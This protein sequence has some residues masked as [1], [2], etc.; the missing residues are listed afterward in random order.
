MALVL[1][2]DMTLS[3]LECHVSLEENQR[4]TAAHIVS[5]RLNLPEA[6]EIGAISVGLLNVIGF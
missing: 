4:R 5:K 1:E 6:I 2:K 3:Y